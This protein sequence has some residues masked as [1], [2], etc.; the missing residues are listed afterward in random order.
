MDQHP[1][2]HNVPYCAEVEVL[3]M[4]LDLSPKEKAGQFFGKKSQDI[5]TENYFFHKQKTF[6][7]VKICKQ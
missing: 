1:S 3:G 6:L 7:Y 2:S 5:C 4:A